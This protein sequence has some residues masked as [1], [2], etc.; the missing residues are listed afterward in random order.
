MKLREI[1]FSRCGD[2][3]DF[4]NVCVFPYDDT[5]W[6][7]LREWMTAE[8]VKEKFGE[9]VLGEVRR[10]EYPRLRGLNFVMANALGGGASVSLRADVMGKTFQS[11]VLDIDIPDALFA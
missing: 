8:V 2:K 5:H 10:Y 3:A 9:L 1:A 7:R 6:P 11:L 4:S